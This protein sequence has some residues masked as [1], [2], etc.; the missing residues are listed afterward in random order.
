MKPKGAKPYD[1]KTGI[2]RGAPG[3]RE[4]FSEMEV[5]S[6]R[7]RGRGSWSRW[8]SKEHFSPRSD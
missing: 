7:E 5:V 6:R 8:K 3:F 2:G 1:P 4:F